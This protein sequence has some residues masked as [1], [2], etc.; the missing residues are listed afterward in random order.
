VGV[1]QSLVRE[2]PVKCWRA[3]ASRPV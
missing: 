3:Q 1:H 2:D